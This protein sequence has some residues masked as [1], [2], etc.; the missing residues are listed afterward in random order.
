MKD[1]K[2]RGF[3]TAFGPF[4]ISSTKLFST[5]SLSSSFCLALHL[6]GHGIFLPLI[7]LIIFIIPNYQIKLDK[8]AIYVGLRQTFT[9]VWMSI[10][11]KWL[12]LR[13]RFFWV[14]VKLHNSIWQ[15]RSFI[16]FTNH[17]YL[18]SIWIFDIIVW[19]STWSPLG[20]VTSSFIAMLFM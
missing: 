4:F 7:C 12:L 16:I 5:I 11:H 1:R 19:L 2:R 13:I 3:L 14:G 20:S 9:F 18:V 6:V 8:K 10:A 15:M 17:F